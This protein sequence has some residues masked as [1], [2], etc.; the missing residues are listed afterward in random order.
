M[1]L[2]IVFYT[3]YPRI[4][5]GFNLVP[6]YKIARAQKNLQICNAD[7]FSLFVKWDWICLAVSGFEALS[8]D[9]VSNKHSVKISDIKLN[10]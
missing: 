1:N 9:D 3:Y 7:V 8:R 2:V 5:W 4:K 10:Y 6:K